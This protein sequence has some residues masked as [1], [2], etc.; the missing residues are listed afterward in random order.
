MSMRRLLVG[1]PRG[2]WPPEPRSRL[3][4]G[5]L[6]SRDQSLPDDPELRTEI[7]MCTDV[8]QDSAL[9][10]GTEPAGRVSIRHMVQ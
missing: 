8:L 9:H 3:G 5:Q 7:G 2:P 6:G 4:A 10:H 1:Q